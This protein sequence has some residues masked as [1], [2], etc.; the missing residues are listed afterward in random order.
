MKIIAIK[1]KYRHRLLITGGTI[2]TSLLQ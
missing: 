2:I 1:K